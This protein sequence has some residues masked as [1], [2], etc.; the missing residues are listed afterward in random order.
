LIARRALLVKDA[1]RFKADSFQVAAPARQAE[2]FAKVR[3]IAV[4]QGSTFTALEDVVEATYRAMV[5]A[6]IAQEQ[7]YFNAMIPETPDE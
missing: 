6:F 2:V 3:A 7:D 4:Q 1:A 5:A